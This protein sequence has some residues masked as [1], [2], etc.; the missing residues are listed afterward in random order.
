VEVTSEA[1]NTPLELVSFPNCSNIPPLGQL[2][3]AVTLMVF[4]SKLERLAL[5]HKEFQEFD[6]EEKYI[7]HLMSV[8]KTNNPFAGVTIAFLWTVVILGI[9]IPF[10]VELTSRTLVGFG[11]AGTSE[12]LTFCC[13]NKNILCENRNINKVL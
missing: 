4:A 12:I 8:S 7:T 10:E 5:S 11:V 1:S 2:A 13:A 3:P 6:A 9:S